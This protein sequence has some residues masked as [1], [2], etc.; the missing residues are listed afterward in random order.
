SLDLVAFAAVVVLGLAFVVG[1]V[2]GSATY[3]LLLPLVTVASAALIAVVVH[4]WAD[5]SRAVFSW[6]PMVEVGKRSYGLYLWSWPIMRIVGAYHGGWSRFLLAMAITIPVSE[7][8]YRFIETPIRRGALGRWWGS[9]ERHDWNMVTTCAAASIGVIALSLTAFFASAPAFYDAA[10]D[11]S[12][13]QVAFES[14]V[15][16]STAPATDASDTSTAD[17]DVA[18]DDTVA[19][20]ETAPAETGPP[21]TA[22][23]LPRKLVIVGD[24]T[25][26]SLAINLP[27]GI[28][29]TFSIAD[30]SVDGCSVYDS[31]KAI[32][33]RNG[34]TRTFSEC[35]GWEQD[36]VSDAAGSEVALVVLGAWDVFDVDVDGQ[37]L[38]FGT[39]END[40]RFKA[41][42]QKGI[43]ALTAAGVKV[44][45]LEIPCMRP[46][47]APGAGVPALPERGDDARVAHLN[48]LLREVASANPNSTVFVTGPAEYCSDPTIATSL[49]YRWDGVHAYKPGAKLTYETIA[50]ALLAI[51]VP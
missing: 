20:V 47:D 4:P 36:W 51:P 34:F 45:L 38:A 32:S 11:T 42:V 16:A 12:N 9:R 8:C 28:G 33:S 37:R 31:G 15:T 50:P 44:A 26:H 27:D 46:V 10:K 40:A 2:E 17:T 3:Y 21:V 1:H 14:P 24:S 18:T 13:D 23:A 30:G 48:Q 25:A 22:A 19:A 35:T 39:P 43:D 7:A 29:G 5:S 41:G 49:A 6:R